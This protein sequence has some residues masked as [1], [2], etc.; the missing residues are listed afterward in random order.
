MKI[1]IAITSSQSSGGIYQYTQSVLKAMGERR[2]PDEVSVVLLPDMQLPA[3]ACISDRWQVVSLGRDLQMRKDEIGSCLSG[4]GLDLSAPGVNHRLNACLS[5]LAIDLMIYP[6][7]SSVSFESGIPYIT[8]VHDLQHRLQ[9]EFP[10]VSAMGEWRRREYLFRNSIRHAGTVL[11]DSE[12][13]REDVLHFYGNLIPPECVRS[14]PFIPAYGLQEGHATPERQAAVREKYDLPERFFFYPAQF[15][16]HKN[17]ARLVHAIHLLRLRHAADTPLVLTGSTTGPEWEGRDLVFRNVMTLAGQLGVSD[18]VRYIGYAPDEDM[19]ALYSMATALTMPTFFGPT[20]IPVLEAWALGCPVLSSDIRGIR[21]QI[22]SAGILVDP[23]NAEDIAS[24]LLR[25]WNDEG[26]RSA[27]VSEGR[28]K[29]DAYTFTRFADRLN[30]IIDAVCGWIANPPA[31]DIRPP[32]N[33]SAAD[34]NAEGESLHA[35]GDIEGAM[36]R[37]C[38][39]VAA[40]DSLHEAHNNLGVCYWQSGRHHEAAGQFA[41]SLKRNPSFK[42]ALMNYAN[43]L[44]SLEK[45]HEALLVCRD[46]LQRHPHDD[47]IVKLAAEITLDAK[48]LSGQKRHLE[49]W[50]DSLHPGYLLSHKIPW[51]T[52]DAVDYLEEII[53]PGMKVF[54]WGSGG[55]TL[56]WLNRGAAQLVSIEHDAEWHAKLLPHVRDFAQADYRLVVPEP[57]PD[58]ADAGDASDPDAYSTCSDLRG[59]S[60]RNYAA[61]I[62][63]FPDCHFDLILIDGRSRPSCIKHCAGKVRPGGTLVLDNADRSYYLSRT[64]QYLQDFTGREFVG[65]APSVNIICQTNVYTKMR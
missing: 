52:F 64:G 36:Q 14:L 4:D 61:Q 37:F 13:G 16:L 56:F 22:G 7:P 62:D 40:D 53:T 3:A 15:W 39:A 8:A 41:I 31:S 44:S 46:Y 63:E 19:P 33:L 20:N 10:E 35:G 50:Q 23:R 42:P 51:I 12:V 6:S 27:L 49:R 9:P 43:A 25:I 48:E 24:G 28:R 26:L 2:S 30:G 60:F 11:A 1:G 29:M 65:L 32:V 55:S 57:L 5:A 59:H 18:L 34:L 21:E 17:H 47:D 54:E 38:A 58:K 45:K